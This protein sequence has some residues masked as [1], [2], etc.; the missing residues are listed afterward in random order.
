MRVVRGVC[1]CGERCVCVWCGE[2]CV[3]VWRE[4]C[5]CGVVRG[6]CVC[7]CGE[8]DRIPRFNFLT[9][10]LEQKQNKAKLLTGKGKD[11][12]RGGNAAVSSTRCPRR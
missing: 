11:L 2:R 4:V 6:V 7:V 5:V 10:R 12:G 3:C 1:V 9:A 8:I